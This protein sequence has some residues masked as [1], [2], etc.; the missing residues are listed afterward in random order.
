MKGQNGKGRKSG[1]PGVRSNNIEYLQETEHLQ[2]LASTTK[3]DFRS[4][5]MSLSAATVMFGDV[6]VVRVPKGRPQW[7]RCRPRKALVIVQPWIDAKNGIKLENDGRFVTIQDPYALRAAY[8]LNAQ[9]PYPGDTPSD[10]VPGNSRF[11]VHRCSDNEF[12]IYDTQHPEAEGIKVDQWLVFGDEFP[13]ALHYAMVL[14][15]QH[16]IDIEGT[17]RWRKTYQ[18]QNPYCDHIRWMLE[19]GYSE[20]EAMVHRESR[21]LHCFDVW[22]ED[23]KFVVRDRWASF[24]TYLD[25]DL[26]MKEG[27]LLRDWYKSHLRKEAHQMAILLSQD[28][29]ENLGLRLDIFEDPVSVDE[30][31]HGLEDMLSQ[32]LGAFGN[33]A[34]GRTANDF[35]IGSDELSVNNVKYKGKKKG[36]EEGTFPAVERNVSVPKDPS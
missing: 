3:S 21:H 6:S 5:G 4:S 13:L 24:V 31:L 10:V 32:L 19:R 18:M 20:F 7:R 22:K 26:A 36:V 23:N 2:D 11:S 34:E 28:S 29:F 15:N 8:L 1:P 35:G 12:A 33:I 17:R 25:E 30:N 14:A 27:F 9:Q 16:N